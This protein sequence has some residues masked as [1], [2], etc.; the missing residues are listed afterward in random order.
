MNKA[1]RLDLFIRKQWTKDGCKNMSMLLAL[2][3]STTVI[4]PPTL[5]YYTYAIYED[6][7]K[8]CDTNAYADK[9]YMLHESHLSNFNYVLRRWLQGEFEPWFD[10]KCS[11]PR[12]MATEKLNKLVEDALTLQKKLSQSEDNEYLRKQT[13]LE[14]VV[15]EKLDKPQGEIVLAIERYI[16]ALNIDRTVV[17]EK[18]L[19]SQIAQPRDDVVTTLSDVLVQ[20]DFKIA[21]LKNQTHPE[22]HEH[23]DTFW[24]DLKRNTTPGISESCLPRDASL[25]D[26]VKEFRKITDLRMSTCV[27]IGVQ[28]YEIHVVLL[29]MFGVLAWGFLILIMDC[30]IR[31]YARE[32]LF[33]ITLEQPY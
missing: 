3:L 9:A 2:V 11:T 28:K 1:S 31:E 26:V 10:K 13:L 8:P 15:A 14:V 4:L 22:Y 6:T 20:F 29:P 30:V 18:F 27:P 33:K 24:S 21:E 17:I 23:I 32:S 16:K 7:S 25:E 12:I 19:V 5:I